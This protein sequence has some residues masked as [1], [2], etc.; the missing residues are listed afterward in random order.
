MGGG[1]DAGLEC[2][3]ELC[4]DLPDDGSTGGETT[5][6]TD[7]TTGDEGGSSS[8]AAGDSTGA[9]GDSTGAAGATS[10]A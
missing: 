4:V 2:G 5:D 3:S 8:G 7:S 9:A 6:P 10:G 1:C